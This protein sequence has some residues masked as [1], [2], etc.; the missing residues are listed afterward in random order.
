MYSVSP[1]M[2]SLPFDSLCSPASLSHSWWFCASRGK[3]APQQTASW[4]E[5]PR[6]LWGS[7]CKWGCGRSE[8]RCCTRE[9]WSEEGN[10]SNLRA[11]NKERKSSTTDS[12]QRERKEKLSPPSAGEGLFQA[13]HTAPWTSHPLWRPRRTLVNRWSGLMSLMT[14]STQ[15][16]FL[17]YNKLRRS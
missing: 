3:S 15:P 2:Q 14:S 17:D 6:N 13:L 1:H 7:S 16:S 9:G 5:P 4:P 11:I 12:A 8:P 10:A